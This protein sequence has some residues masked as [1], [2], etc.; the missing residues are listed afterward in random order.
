MDYFF[1]SAG[2]AFDSVTNPDAF[3]KAYPSLQL[4]KRRKWRKI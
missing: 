2:R 3:R 4:T 1:C